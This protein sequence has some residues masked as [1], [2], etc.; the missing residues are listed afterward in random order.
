MSRSHAIW[1]TFALGSSLLLHGI[2][3]ASLAAVPRHVTKERV[4]NLV[5][6]EVSAAKPLP[7]ATP[8]PA[9]EIAE[10]EELR[11]RPPATR[12]P[13]PAATPTTP[14]PVTAE[15]PPAAAAPL[16]LTGVTLTGDQ[17]AFNMPTGNGEARMGPIGPGI[18]PAAAP[19][20]GAVPTPPAPAG[21]PLV[22]L[23]DLSERPS[24]PS[25]ESALLAHYPPDARQR[26]L[27]GTAT[28]RARI[29][30]DGVVRRIQTLSES[31]PGFG[32]ACR[33]TVLGSRW[34]APRDRDGRLVATEIR[35]TCRFLVNR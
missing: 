33:K 27:S 28:V 4:R 15:P 18:R 35:Y 6:F 21:P 32:E 34:G 30:P 25:L 5:T 1:A 31:V 10:P 13:T 16:D 14:T 17:G 20:A 26:G 9:A 7:T 12:N 3:Y 11:A 22:A 24:P 23:S 2:C 19:I 29:E 8:E